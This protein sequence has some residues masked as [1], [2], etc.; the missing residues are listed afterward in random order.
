[1]NHLQIA[2]NKIHPDDGMKEIIRKHVLEGKRSRKPLRYAVLIASCAACILLIVCLLPALQKNKGVYFGTPETGNV[3]A[4]GFA[5]TR[6]FIIFN[7]QYYRIGESYRT[8][9]SVTENMNMSIP[10]DENAKLLI[11]EKLGTTALNELDVNQ[12]GV[13]IQEAGNYSDLTSNVPG[14]EIYTVKGYDLD[15]VL[16]S[17]DSWGIIHFFLPVQPD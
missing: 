8:S 12:E 17:I 11:G 4:G 14:M 15:C 16:M 7:G 1:M 9:L 10:Y 5:D 3:D 13:F 6:Q 2:I